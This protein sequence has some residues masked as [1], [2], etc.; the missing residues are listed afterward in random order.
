MKIIK[1]EDGYNTWYSEK[2]K[3]TYHSSHGVLQEA[4]HVF[5]EGSAAS[6][7]LKTE[8]KV[9]V[10]EIGFGAGFNFF[11]TAAEARKNNTELE[12]YSVEN[13]MPAYQDFKELKHDTLF[14][15][16]PQ[17][18]NFMSWRKN[19]V[20]LKTGMHRMD[21]D[22]TR[23][24]LILLDALHMKLPADYF[25]AV[26][27]DAFSPDMNPE[28]WTLEFFKKVHKAMKEGTRLATY[29]AKSAVRRTLT[30]AGF[31]VEKKSG[32]KGKREMLLAIKK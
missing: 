11:L 28:L 29:S 14:K 22:D 27:H 2:Y 12:Y 19:T 17:W 13:D 9:A 21:L 6:A 3:Q 23:L 1:A 7:L 25:D 5:L 24:I 15:N 8:K 18:K 16:N 10:L 31:E 20:Y 26:Y 30:E 32:P 4:R